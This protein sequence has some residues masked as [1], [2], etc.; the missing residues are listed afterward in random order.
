MVQ[1]IVQHD[2][3]AA[4]V[5][6]L[7]EVGS[8]MFVD[9]NEGV[10]SFR[11]NFATPRHAED[12]RDLSQIGAAMAM[13]GFSRRRGPAAV[14]QRVDD[15]AARTLEEAKDLRDLKESQAQLVAN[16]NHLVELS[17]VLQARHAG[18]RRRHKETHARG[19]AAAARA[20][21]PP[22]CAPTR[23]RALPWP[24]GLAPAARS[25]ALPPRSAA[26]RGRRRPP[27]PPSHASQKCGDIFSR[28]P[29]PTRATPSRASPPS[30]R[31][32]AA[33][34]GRS[35]CWRTAVWRGAAGW[36]ST[37]TGGSAT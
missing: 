33:P 17:H 12:G 22:T 14:E 8:I 25:P 35:S 16:Y 37:R 27:T 21:R 30:P 7:G 15:R 26:R 10:T 2:A 4:T 36:G 23:A 31:P 1:M 34:A 18:R 13:A 28:R 5:E 6:A 19:P 24:L 29:S 32:A 9:L 11:R 20:R 3:A